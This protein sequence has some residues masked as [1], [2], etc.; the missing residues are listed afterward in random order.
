MQ[1]KYIRGTPEERFWRKVDPCRSDGCAVWLGYTFVSSHQTPGSE[2]YGMFRLGNKMILAHHFLVGKPPAGLVWDHV[3]SRGCTHTT[4]VWPDHLELV[5]N[6][7]NVARGAAGEW[8][9]A[10]THCAQGHPF[11]E[12]NTYRYKGNRRCRACANL[13]ERRLRAKR[14]AMQG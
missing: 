12:A 7:E 2:G 8:Q 5:T 6:Q 11:D 1:P 10:R 9:R 3:K 4:C 14:R 13:R